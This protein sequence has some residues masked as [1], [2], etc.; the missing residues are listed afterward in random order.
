M[1]GW[2]RIICFEL[3]FAGFFDGFLFDESRH[4]LQLLYLHCVNFKSGDE[5]HPGRRWEVVPAIPGVIT[6]VAVPGRE[7]IVGNSFTYLVV[8]QSV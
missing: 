5:S 6:L 8:R 1:D 7:V 3:D 2:K 4:L